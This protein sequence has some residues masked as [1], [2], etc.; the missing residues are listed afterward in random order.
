MTKPVETVAGTVI[1][2][3]GTERS[4][5]RNTYTK[6]IFNADGSFYTERETRVEFGTFGN[7]N[8]ARGH[9]WRRAS[10]KQAETFKEHLSRAPIRRGFS[11][12]PERED[13]GM[14]LS[15]KMLDAMVDAF[16]EGWREEDRERDGMSRPG[17]RRRAGLAKALKLIG[18]EADDSWRRA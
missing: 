8:S 7:A 17:D 14:K 3:D 6:T 13:E 10:A 2:A 1:M 5:S 11:V 18:I 12:V 4:A 16:G 15:S 9:S